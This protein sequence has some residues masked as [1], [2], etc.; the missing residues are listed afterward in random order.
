MCV[1]ITVKQTRIH[2]TTTPEK[3]SPVRKR[4]K[5]RLG[6]RGKERGKGRGRKRGRK[7]RE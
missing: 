7:R 3:V 2:N 6:R 1:N 5:G 4:R